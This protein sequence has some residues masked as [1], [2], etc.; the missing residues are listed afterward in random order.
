M[1]IHLQCLDGTEGLLLNEIACA[2]EKSLGVD[3]KADA[4]R[5]MLSPEQRVAYRELEDALCQETGAI[6]LATWRA[7]QGAHIG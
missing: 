3:A 4:F 1:T 5:E 2:V 6:Q 7:G